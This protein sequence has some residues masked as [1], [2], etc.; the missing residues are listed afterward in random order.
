MPRQLRVFLCHAHSDKD[1]VKALYARLK[2]EGVDV[3]LDKEKLLPGADWEF[4]IR[5]AVRE[6]DV[7]IVCLS[8][9]FNQAGFRQKEVRIALEEADRKPEGEIFIIPA[10]L[11]EC[12][13]LE[14]LSRW[15]WV[16]MFESDGFQ[17]LILALRIRAEKI[18]AALRQRG[19]TISRPKK[20]V[21]QK[22]GTEIEHIENARRE[23][24]EQEQQRLAKE[25][26]DHETAEK[27]ERDR[28]EREAA[29]KAEQDRFDRE[30]AEKA[31]RDLL[32]REAVEKA[33]REKVAR[34]KAEQENAE[35]ERL[36]REAK[37][38]AAKQKTDPHLPTPARKLDLPGLGI[39][40]IIFVCAILAFIGVNY[41][42]ENLPSLPTEF[43]ETITVTVSKTI[44]PPPTKTITPIQPTFTHT[45]V[46]LI[47]EIPTQTPTITLII[48]PPPIYGKVQANE[49][50]GANLRD[51]PGGNYVM[52]LLN[53]TLIE[54]Y[55]EI[56]Q[57]ND[58][59]WIKIY[60]QVNGIKIEGWLLERVIAYT[61][62]TPDFEATVPPTFT[63]AP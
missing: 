38:N 1:T 25:Q 19:A 20:S 21:E 39:A 53:G 9:Q 27:A 29:A 48:Q 47:V 10:R 44:P 5:K 7:V 59:T 36:A 56:Q 33:E 15:H 35:R 46:P 2:R 50:G 57:L 26:A 18:G 61:T 52:T 43:V 23:E 24:E 41:L 62:P 63:F 16:D 3:W 54:T 58:N 60:A 51:A 55:S 22:Q 28:L 8:K 31:E 17:R 14:S 30:A 13:N 32:E 4:E 40:G 11:E 45:S 49:G 37:A 34:L 6:S 42:L 12:D